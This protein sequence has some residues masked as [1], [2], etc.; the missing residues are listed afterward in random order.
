MKPHIQ[1]NGR[2]KILKR[3]AWCINWLSENA[4]GNMHTDIYDPNKNGIVN[5]AEKVNNHSVY[6]D[7]PSDAVFT[8]TVY[9]DTSIKGQVR[10]NMNNIELL[11]NEL[12]E[13]DKHWLVDADGNQIIDSNG[14][15]IYT[16]K[17]NSQLEALQNQVN[18]LIQRLDDLGLSV[19]D[20]MLQVT[21][22][23]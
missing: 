2:S 17:F 5:N 18:I 1:Y 15:P 23:E 8:D 12:F 13:Q 16:A 14:N 7:V 11:M 10:A 4:G 19:V 9:D 22:E 20:G 21:Y 3:L 6:K